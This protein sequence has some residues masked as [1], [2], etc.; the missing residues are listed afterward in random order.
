MSLEWAESY[1]RSASKR[2]AVGR[3]DELGKEQAV[4]NFG[5]MGPLV[6]MVANH[7]CGQASGPT[8]LITTE[9]FRAGIMHRSRQWRNRLRV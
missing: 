8:Q 9:V 4:G 6:R 3:V 5:V 7:V 1:G 2:G